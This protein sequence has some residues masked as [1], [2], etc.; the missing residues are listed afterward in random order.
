MQRAPNVLEPALVERLRE[1]DAGDLGTDVRGERP[2][3]EALVGQVAI[4]DL[5][6]ETGE[7]YTG[8]ANSVTILLVALLSPVL[9]AAA[10]FAAVKKKLLFPIHEG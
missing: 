9:G 1:V 4:G 6:Q 10:D 7:I 8:I 2:E 3:P 5:S